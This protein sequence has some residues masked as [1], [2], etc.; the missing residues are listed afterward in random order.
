MV[1]GA[2]PAADGESL[3]RA[4]APAQ[5][6]RGDGVR[7]DSLVVIGLRFSSLLLNFVLLFV[8]AHVMTLFQFGVASTALAL[9]NIIVVP[10]TLGCD[11]AAI[12]YVALFRH[13]RPD[14]E[15]VTRWLLR[16]VIIASIAVMA[17]TLVAA[18]IERHSG[19][20][21]LALGIALLVPTIPTFALMRFGEGWLR[22][23]GSLI[24]AQLSSNLIVPGLSIVVV[25]GVWASRSEQLAIGSVLVIRALVGLAAVFLTAA[26]VRRRLATLVEAEG[27][28]AV[29]PA[30]LRRVVIGLVGG[31]LLAMVA[32]QIDIIAVTSILGARTG[33]IYS[34][35]ARVALA[36]N[37]AVVSVN[38]GLAPRAARWAHDRRALQAMVSSAANFSAAIMISGCLILIAGA[39]LVMAAFGPAFA[40]GANPLRILLLGQIVNGICGPVGTVMNMSGRQHYSM[41]TQAAALVIQVT[42]LGV[43]TPLVG[44]VGAA[45]ATAVANAAW[46]IAMA[47]FVRRELGVWALPLVGGVKIRR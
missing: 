47:G 11:T 25:V 20:R 23:S 36:M 5:P 37:L 12:R 45:S 4:A 15:L 43:L 35:A 16:R 32:T 44:L 2:P 14:L 1:E 42:L 6:V 34:A 17:V 26:F 10:A 41:W 18:A 28:A 8:L 24:R 22:G 39:G 33:G 40:P 29:L 27:E 38:F 9:L 30:G 13:R 7:L 19:H 31:A 3:T 46:N 21:T